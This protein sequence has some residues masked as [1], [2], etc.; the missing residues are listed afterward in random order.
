[1]SEYF[2][3]NKLILL[4]G[5]LLLLAGSLMISGT[6]KSEAQIRYEASSY[7]LDEMLRDLPN[8]AKGNPGYRTSDY[9]AYRLISDQQDFNRLL[10][11]ILIISGLG[12]SL[13][14]YNKI[15][16]KKK[17]NDIYFN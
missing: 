6:F 15:K 1:M 11:I 9:D 13:F 10:S 2:C 4:A 3:M 16:E 14:A 8:S 12:L 5:I 7:Q 17:S